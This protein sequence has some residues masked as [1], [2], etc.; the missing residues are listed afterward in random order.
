MPRGRNK[1]LL[2]RRD[3]KLLRRYYEL[4]EV[5]N[6]RFD[7]ALTLLSKDEFFISEARIMA[8]IRKNCNRLGDID[9]NPV[10]KVRK[11]K[12]TARQLALFKTDEKS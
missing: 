8:I 6:L 12:L 5:Q 1:E 7:R 2:S 11:P 4:T 3:E 9:V 10:P